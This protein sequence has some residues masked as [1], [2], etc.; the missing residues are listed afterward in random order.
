VTAQR[1][2][3][4]IFLPGREY[5]TLV[6]AGKPAGRPVTESRVLRGGS[7]NNNQDNARAD[8]RNNNHPDNRNNNIGF[9]VVCSSHIH[10]RPPQCRQIPP[11]T[12]GGMRRRP[13]DGAGA[14]SPHAATSGIG[15]IHKRGAAWA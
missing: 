12:A 7:W 8:N 13:L 2:V 1:A 3:T 5:A 4:E 10:L 15:R 14:S 9:R 6:L 11:V